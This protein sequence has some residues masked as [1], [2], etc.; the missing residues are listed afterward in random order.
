MTE[1]QKLA[2]QIRPTL[3]ESQIPLLDSK[4]E[5]LKKE[6]SRIISL[7]DKVISD[8]EIDCTLWKDYL[9]LVNKIMDILKV[10]LPRENPTSVM[11]MKTSIKRL[12]SYLQEAQKNQALV[13]DLN[14]KARALDRRASQASSELINRQLSNINSQWQEQLC[15]VENELSALTDVLNQWEIYLE[16]DNK[17]STTLRDCET[18][19]DNALL[20]ADDD[21]LKVCFLF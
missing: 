10:P 15:T 11:S 12:S 20:T 7:A 5:S 17:V 6:L 8:T 9:E 16:V 1:M 18:R 19:F 14:E 3:Q 4:I 13:N 21:L 2:S